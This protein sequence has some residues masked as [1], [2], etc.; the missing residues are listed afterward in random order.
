MSTVR[1]LIFCK[2]GVK[3]EEGRYKTDLIR[4]LFI[5]FNRIFS[6]DEQLFLIYAHF[7]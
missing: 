4:S 3:A 7:K 1:N 6:W 2:D 5:F